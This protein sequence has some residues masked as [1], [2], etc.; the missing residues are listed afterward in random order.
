MT[1]QD[2]IQAKY[3]TYAKQGASFILTTNNGTKFF[4]HPRHSQQGMMVDVD[5]GHV[6]KTVYM[7]VEQ[8]TKLAKVAAY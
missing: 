4:V 6:T 1:N 2:Q 7:T 3:E 8:I 5:N